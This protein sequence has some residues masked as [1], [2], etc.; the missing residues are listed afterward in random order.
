MFR[1][2][3]APCA[4]AQRMLVRRAQQTCCAAACIARPLPPRA[5]L[6]AGAMHICIQ[7]RMQ[8]ALLFALQANYW[9]LKSM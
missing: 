2:D 7:G 4:H 9:T 8:A 3:G 1:R 6:L 5:P